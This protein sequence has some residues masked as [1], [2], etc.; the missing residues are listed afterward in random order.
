ETAPCLEPAGSATTGLPAPLALLAVCCAQSATS[1]AY[2]SLS[3]LYSSLMTLMPGKMQTTTFRLPL[4][5]YFHHRRFCT[6]RKD[7]VKS[8]PKGPDSSIQLKF[9]PPDI[10]PAPLPNL[11]LCPDGE[12][13]CAPAHRLHAGSRRR[14][15]I[16]LVFQACA[17][18]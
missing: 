9:S 10:S 1:L 17:D 4:G 2:L 11:S 13:R 5:F 8:F 15:C 6:K 12:V 7:G 16:T 18:N 14:K 3:V